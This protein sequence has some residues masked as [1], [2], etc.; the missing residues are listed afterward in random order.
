M[1]PEPALTPDSDGFILTGE[2]LLHRA[3]NGLSSGDWR[4]S[5]GVAAVA[6]YLK[7]IAETLR[8]IDESLKAQRGETDS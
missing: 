7:D 6:V 3:T 8:S 2:T 5:S 4:L 1:K